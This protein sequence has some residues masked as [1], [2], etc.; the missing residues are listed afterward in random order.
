[1]KRL[2]EDDSDGVKHIVDSKLGLVNG[3]TNTST[4]GEFS[5]F[6]CVDSF[7]LQDELSLLYI[8]RYGSFSTFRR[9]E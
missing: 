9:G 5:L 1:M 7:T 4:I 2:R 8:S 6:S 3:D